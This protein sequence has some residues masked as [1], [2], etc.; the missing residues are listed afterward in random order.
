[1]D[2]NYDEI[3]NELVEKNIVK[4]RENGNKSFGMPLIIKVKDAEVVSQIRGVT[5]ELT[6]G[7]SEHDNI[8]DEQKKIVYDRYY[9]KLK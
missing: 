1:M 9:D 7:Q 3:M 2:E 5:Y 4:V 8:N 6:D